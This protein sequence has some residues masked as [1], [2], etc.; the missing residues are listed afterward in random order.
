VPNGCRCPRKTSAQGSF[1][2]RKVETLRTLPSLKPALS[3]VSTL[4][5]EQQGLTLRVLYRP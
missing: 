4:K 1:R 2:R 5:V 3:S